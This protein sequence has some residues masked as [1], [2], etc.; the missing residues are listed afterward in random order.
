MLLLL[1]Y[2]GEALCAKRANCE[3]FLP[4]THQHTERKLRRLL[5]SISVII[6]APCLE[7]PHKNLHVSICL[8][9]LLYSGIFCSCKTTPPTPAASRAGKNLQVFEHHGANYF[10]SFGAFMGGLL[11]KFTKN[12][13]EHGSRL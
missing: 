10:R 2:G 4:Y 12:G 5:N 7:L 13:R 3:L 9:L 1:R 11:N 8:A 6:S